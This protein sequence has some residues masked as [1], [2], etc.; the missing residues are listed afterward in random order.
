MDNNDMNDLIKKAQ[1]MIKNNQIPDEVKQIV[2]GM[3][4]NNMNSNGDYSQGSNGSA[5]SSQMPSSS[6]PGTNVNMNSVM[7]MFSKFSSQAS[8]DD[9]TRLL[10][11]LK[12]YLRNERKDKIDEYVKLIKMGKMA[13]LLD[14]LNNNN[15]K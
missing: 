1:D 4:V 3:S 5:N 10:F 7:S 12:P 6:K 14:V 2:S 11:A 8:D 13:Q 9:M 15:N